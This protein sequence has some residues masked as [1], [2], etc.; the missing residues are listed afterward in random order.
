[1]AN[2][3]IRN[4][5]NELRDDFKKYDKTMEIGSISDGGSKYLVYLTSKNL[6]R[7]EA[8]LDNHYTWDKKTR[9]ITPFRV[10]DDP[11]FYDI[12][13]RHIIYMAPGLRDD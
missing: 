3:K 2:E 13:T 8:I 12:A 10:T 11:T 9:K 1:M 5:I 6:K 4:R 7:G